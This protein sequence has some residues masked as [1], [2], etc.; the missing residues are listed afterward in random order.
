MTSVVAL[1]TAA[2]PLGFS[3]QPSRMEMKLMLRSA[4]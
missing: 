3:L 4:Y 2:R 1:T